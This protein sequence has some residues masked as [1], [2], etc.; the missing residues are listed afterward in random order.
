VGQN[1]FVVGVDHMLNV[2]S[3]RRDVSSHSLVTLGM[4]RVLSQAFGANQNGES[5]DEPADKTLH[6]FLL[7]DEG[8]KGHIWM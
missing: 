6:V 8:C 4:W 5:K 7:E 2:D 1:G 3:I